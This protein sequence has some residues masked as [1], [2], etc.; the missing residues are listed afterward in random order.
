MPSE[1]YLQ[2]QHVWGCPVYVLDPRLQDGKKIPKWDP[3]VRRGQFLGFST[4]HSSTIG[5]VLNHRTGSVT[6]QYHCVYDD[7]FTTV[8]NG[9]FAP[10]FDTGQFAAD[11]WERLI[12]TGGWERA[13]IPCDNDNCPGLRLDDEWR[14]PTDL[15][16]MREEELQK[17]LERLTDP[18]NLLEPPLVPRESPTLL[19]DLDPQDNSFDLMDDDLRVSLEPGIVPPVRDLASDFQDKAA[20]EPRTRQMSPPP[21]VRRLERVRKPNPRFKGDEWAKYQS[22]RLTTQRVRA[23]LLNSQF[24]HSLD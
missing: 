1:L 8:P 6:P 14:S 15:E 9:E 10:V 17:Q 5:L 12:T 18:E 16:R 22:S 24:L 3:R 19:R 11:D 23:G 7:L 20:A 2:H 21:G 4:Q 13:D